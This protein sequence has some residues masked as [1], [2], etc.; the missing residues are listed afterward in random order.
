MLRG[1]RCLLYFCV[2]F[3]CLFFL[4]GFKFNVEDLGVLVYYYFIGSIGNGWLEDI[5]KC[6]ISLFNIEF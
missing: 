5:V 3:W 4:L 6:G 1:F 2:I